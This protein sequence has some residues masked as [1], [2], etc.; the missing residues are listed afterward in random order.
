MDTHTY[1]H[2]HRDEEERMDKR[3]EKL[4][5]QL[6]KTERENDDLEVTTLMCV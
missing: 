5:G 4:D 2:T 6:R 3:Y 1:T